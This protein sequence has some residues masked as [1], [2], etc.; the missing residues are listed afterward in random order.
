[1]VSA[2]L[3]DRS[4]QAALALAVHTQADHTHATV[5]TSPNVIMQRPDFATDSLAG[6]LDGKTAVGATVVLGACMLS[7]FN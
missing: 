3:L 4:A 7:S 6:G 1:M 2:V 5:S